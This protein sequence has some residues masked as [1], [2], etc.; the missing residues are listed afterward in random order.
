[1]VGSAS[2]S[3]S[4]DTFANSWLKQEIPAGGEWSSS[5]LVSGDDGADEGERRGA[6]DSRREEADTALGRA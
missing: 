5:G 1:V 4:A 6:C 3:D 2:G